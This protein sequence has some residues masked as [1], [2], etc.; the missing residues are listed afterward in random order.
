MKYGTSGQPGSIGHLKWHLNFV[1]HSYFPVNGYKSNCRVDVY[2]VNFSKLIVITNGLGLKFV[3]G[4][5][6]I[7]TRTLMNC[8]DK[9][10][11]VNISL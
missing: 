6:D 10:V 8:L 5:C 4:E 11:T 7:C 1:V 2:A 3:C 9:T